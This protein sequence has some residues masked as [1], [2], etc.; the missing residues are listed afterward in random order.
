MRIGIKGTICITLTWAALALMPNAGAAH[1]TN[2]LDA[3]QSEVTNR[4]AS[5]GTNETRAEIRALSNA[6]RTLNRNTKTLSADLGLLATTVVQLHGPFADDAELAQLET[7][8]IAA[9]SSE[10]HARLDSIYLWIGTNDVTRGLSN[11][12]ARAEA[13]LEHADGETNGLAAQARTL[14]KA[15]N[16]ILPVERK[17]RGLFPAP[18]IVPPPVVTNPPPV[19]PPPGVPPGTPGLAPDSFGTRH[20]DLYENDV[21]NDQTVFYFSTAATGA[22]IYNVHH[23]EEL[24]LWV[25]I[26]T[27]ADTGVIMVDPDYPDNAPQR[28]LY[29]TFTSANGGTFTGTTFF[30]QALQGTFAVIQ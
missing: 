15:F 13:A 27:G 23:P 7:D 1:A 29:L 6:A 25:Y 16:K 24:G 14:A 12:V 21:V 20:V 22:Q 9:Y 17:V 26:R 8:A 18:I 4:L 19:Q 3:L 30:G 2:F 11:R 28:P 5:A 10:A